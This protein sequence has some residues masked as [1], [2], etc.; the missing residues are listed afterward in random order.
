MGRLLG[1]ALTLLVGTVCCGAPAPAKKP[2]TVYHLCCFIVDGEKLT[3][4]QLRK[5]LAPLELAKVRDVTPDFVA[6]QYLRSSGTTWREYDVYI[7]SSEPYER[8]LEAIKAKR[9]VRRAWEPPADC[10]KRTV[11]QIP[12]PKW[13]VG[14]PLDVPHFPDCPVHQ[15]KP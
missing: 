8:V 4:E 15:K 1:L 2:K 10:Y 3:T 5:L 6:K 14:M 12:V 9:G 11:E 7:R 13:S